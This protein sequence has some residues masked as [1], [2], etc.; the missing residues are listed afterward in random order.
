M[1]PHFKVHLK[2][3]F[4]YLTFKFF[5]LKSQPARTRKLALLKAP[6]TR[7]G[8]LNH[9]WPIGYYPSDG[10]PT[11]PQPR[12]TNI[13][14]GADNFW[15]DNFCTYIW[16]SFYYLSLYYNNNN[17]NNHL[18][19]QPR[20][21]TFYLFSAAFIYVDWKNMKERVCVCFKLTK[22]TQVTTKKAYHNRKNQR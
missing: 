11:Y 14:V 9:H 21:F 13:L 15:K 6:K 18:L 4:S 16:F 12:F 3:Q 20:H 2:F 19:I 7:L 10:W 17:N 1:A 5:G 22:E 8:V